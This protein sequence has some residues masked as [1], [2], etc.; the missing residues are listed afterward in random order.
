MVAVFSQRN[1]IGREKLI[2]HKVIFPK[3]QQARNVRHI[4]GLL[5]SCYFASILMMWKFCTS[6]SGTGTSFGAK[7]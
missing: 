5:P 1:S 7:L 4:P 3:K 6:K 2:A